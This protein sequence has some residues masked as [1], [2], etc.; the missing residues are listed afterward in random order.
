MTYRTASFAEAQRNASPKADD[1][2]ILSYRG[3]TSKSQAFFRK[4]GESHAE[5][6]RLRQQCR[7]AANGS[8][9]RNKEEK[10]QLNY[11]KTTIAEARAVSSYAAGAIT[12]DRI[13][14][15]NCAG[16][17][18]WLGHL[19]DPKHFE[20]KEETPKASALPALTDA[21]PR[22]DVLAPG[23]LEPYQGGRDDYSRQL[24]EA[25]V[26]PGG[27]GYSAPTLAQKDPDSPKSLPP[28]T[29]DIGT[30]E[31]SH[32]APEDLAPAATTEA[33]GSSKGSAVAPPSESFGG[34][35]QE[36]GSEEDSSSEEDESDASDAWPPDPPVLRFKMRMQFSNRFRP[37][38]GEKAL[39]ES[40]NEDLKDKLHDS[41]KKKMDD[42]VL[43]WMNHV[44]AM[45]VQTE[46]EFEVGFP[47]IVLT[48]LDAIYPKR[49]RW[50]EVDWKFQYKRCLHKNFAVLETVWN[51]VNMEKAREFRVEN[52][53][54]RLEYLPTAALPEKL[55]FTRLMK[56]WYDQRIHHAGKYDPMAKRLEFVKQC[57][58]WG[59]KVKFPEWIL[60]D[61]EYK[62]EISREDGR[63]LEKS[64]AYNK[65][66]E[67]QRLIH[68]LGCQEYQTM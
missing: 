29:G 30:L 49:V 13:E 14:N 39:F 36:E 11:I 25:L 27:S 58:A 56:R 57:N 21:S 7:S 42:S 65:M 26:G 38:E 51:E 62:V 47:V 1:S 50:R 59:H 9:A 33:R 66:P 5:A 12:K 3:A 32:A 20:Q 48:M 43:A 22:P 41:D 64:Q 8:A 4:M 37:S 52:T 46:H 34:S 19:A 17:P 68:F 54:L 61:K 40:M 31:N 18:M 67:Y 35:V 23:A 28:N 2:E 63:E 15:F 55:E 24:S 10:V 44:F 16:S 53:S 45:N 6:E 60:F